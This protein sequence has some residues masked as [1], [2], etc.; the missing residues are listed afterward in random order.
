LKKERKYYE[1]N[2]SITE[3]YFALPNQFYSYHVVGL[4]NLIKEDVYHLLIMFCCSL[5]SILAYELPYVNLGFTSFL[6]GGPLRP[7]PGYYWEQYTQCYTSNLFT[8]SCGKRLCHVPSP[9]LT[10][11]AGFTEL[12]Y[13]SDDEIIG[14]GKWGVDVSFAYLMMAPLEKNCINMRSSGAGIGDLTLGAFRAVCLS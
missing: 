4:R 1:E 2:L 13:Q 7:K 9:R 14:T 3:H 8:N 6:D 11:I 12:I 10:Y 5:S